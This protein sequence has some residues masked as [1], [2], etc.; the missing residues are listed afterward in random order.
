MSD[1][2]IFREVDEHGLGHFSYDQFLQRQ[3]W[4]DN[5]GA[6]AHFDRHDMNGDGVIGI[7]EMRTL[8]SWDQFW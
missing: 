1:D 4:R 7:D 2:D 5:E 8:D 3:G 6:R